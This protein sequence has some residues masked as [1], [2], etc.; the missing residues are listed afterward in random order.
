MTTATLTNNNARITDSASNSDARVGSIIKAIR[1]GVSMGV[2]ELASAN[3]ISIK[4]LVAI[5]A[6]RATTKEERELIPRAVAWHINHLI[7]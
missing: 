7:A 4:R 3:G 1:E 2:A 5:E 6:G